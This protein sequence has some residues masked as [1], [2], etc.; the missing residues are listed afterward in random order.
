MVPGFLSALK[1]ATTAVAS[2]WD[3]ISAPGALIPD[4]TSNI[5]REAFNVIQPILETRLNAAGQRL[6][7]MLDALEGR[8]DTIPKNWIDDMEMLEADYSNWVVEAEKR[9]L[10]SEL[11]RQRKDNLDS[12][13]D[14]TPSEQHAKD[15]PKFSKPVGTNQNATSETQ[16]DDVHEDSFKQA[17]TTIQPSG[18]PGE[19][20]KDN[21]FGSRLPVNNGASEDGRLNIANNE[22]EPP[23]SDGSNFTGIIKSGNKTSPPSSMEPFILRTPT[24]PDKGD[25]YEMLTPVTNETLTPTTAGPRN[26]YD[27]SLRPLSNG[28]AGPPDN[29]PASHVDPAILHSSE[30][31][32]THIDPSEELLPQSDFFNGD[33]I[34][35][36]SVDSPADS[37]LEHQLA[38][39]SSKSSSRTPSHQVSGGLEQ[40]LTEINETRGD[41]NERNPQEQDD[42]KSKSEIPNGP[43]STEP[44]VHE[45]NSIPSAGLSRPATPNIDHPA[46]S[47]PSKA[48]L[49]ASPGPCSRALLSSKSACIPGLQGEEPEPPQMPGACGD[50]K[51]G[52]PDPAPVLSTAE[53]GAAPQPTVNPT[54]DEN[55]A[56][57]HGQNESAHK[58]K[59][60]SSGAGDVSHRPTPLD[61]QRH[62]KHPDLSMSS[63]LSQPNSAAS[64]FYSTASSPEIWDARAAQSFGKP[65][66]VTS[67]T[68]S[69]RIDPE[70]TEPVGWSPIQ[71]TIRA[72]QDTYFEEDLASSATSAHRRVRGTSF[73]L[74]PTIPEYPKTLQDE[75][76]DPAVSGHDFEMRRASVASIEVLSR[77]DVSSCT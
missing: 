52:S 16:R 56:P 63:D 34:T 17:Q 18:V 65:V 44:Q 59:L 50:E 54:I 10:Q 68:R 14:L 45:P 55:L 75:K 77:N 12:R 51:A 3:T 67:P 23:G 9:V 73:A 13:R 43:G 37:L 31:P 47:W 1:E 40:D 69:S 19:T 38:T 5:S 20:G 72:S 76:T 39:P 62:N 4:G 66:E 61:L 28:S 71:Q 30:P 70:G 53:T 60:Q 25:S 15:Q 35:V 8:E 36:D 42:S 6:D 11:P 24:I 46:E 48:P 26:S 7:R 41:P 21:L 74:A 64:D 32:V 58:H 57:P 2:A 33:S 49:P 29:D 27:A 22:T